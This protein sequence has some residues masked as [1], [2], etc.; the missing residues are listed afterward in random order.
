MVDRVSYR[1][2]G[3]LKS[4][5]NQWFI[6]ECCWKI[7]DLKE[8]EL[9]DDAKKKAMISKGIIG[10]RQGLDN[11]NDAVKAFPQCETAIIRSQLDVIALKYGYLNESQTE[12]TNQNHKKTSE[13]YRANLEVVNTLNTN[14]GLRA[15][16]AVFLSK[17]P[18]EVTLGRNCL[19]MLAML[20]RFETAVLQGTIRSGVLK[21]AMVMSKELK[22]SEYQPIVT[23]LT[24]EL[25]DLSEKIQAILERIPAGVLGDTAVKAQIQSELA[26]LGDTHENTVK[27]FRLFDFLAHIYC[28][29]NSSLACK[30]AAIAKVVE[31]EQGAMSIAPKHQVVKDDF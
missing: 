30:L 24:K 9:L 17:N 19:A 1:L 21:T 3:E 4:Y 29:V 6:P 8:L 12:A 13:S 15:S 11:N 27:T 5:S 16:A 31:E 20:K 18:K 10:L 23:S 28:D 2:T 22:R 25:T 26:Q 14:M 7:P